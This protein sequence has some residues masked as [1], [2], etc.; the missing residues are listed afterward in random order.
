MI[1]SILRE[2]LGNFFTQVM[3]LF[4]MYVCISELGVI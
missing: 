1:T 3:A 2:K 4:Q